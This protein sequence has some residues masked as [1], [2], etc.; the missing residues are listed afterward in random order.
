MVLLVVRDGYGERHKLEPPPDRMISSSHCRAMV[1]VHYQLVRR[2]ELE[3]VVM[4]EA[5]LESVAAGELL[6]A[7]LREASVSIDFGG[8]HEAR[9]SE[10][11]HARRMSARGRD[12]K[13]GIRL[14]CV[15]AKHLQH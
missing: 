15:V 1:G 12:Q 14:P 8:H 4:H 9:A 6:D 2:L 13:F 5:S 7:G 11:G 3:E 10:V